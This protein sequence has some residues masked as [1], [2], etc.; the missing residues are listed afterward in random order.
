MQQEA[1][2]LEGFKF[3]R[4]DG[5]TKIS[6]RERIVKVPLLC[7]FIK[8]YVMDLITSALLFTCIYIP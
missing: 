1:I 5:T 6:E 7:L 2:L 4:I 3:L 8:V